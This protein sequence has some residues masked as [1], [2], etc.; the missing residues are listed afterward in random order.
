VT[1]VDLLYATDWTQDADG[2][3]RVKVAQVV[4]AHEDALAACFAGQ[5]GARIEVSFHWEGGRPIRIDVPEESP[6]AECVQR[7]IA[8][9]RATVVDPGPYAWELVVPVTA[10][11]VS[12]LHDDRRQARSPRAEFYLFGFRGSDGR[13]YQLSY[14]LPPGP[15]AEAFG[16]AVQ[17]RLERF[18]ACDLS[19]VQRS[20]EIRWV[21]SSGKLADGAVWIQGGLRAPEIACLADAGDGIPLVG[22]ESLGITFH[23]PGQP[24]LQ[25]IRDGRQ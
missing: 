5:E 25:I 24:K 10:P 16:R 13:P 3:S 7:E 14:H 11:Q 1:A 12:R 17:E 8:S 15:D 18:A 22:V 4:Q 20:A 23:R 21:A 9:W 19:G 6:F 2:A